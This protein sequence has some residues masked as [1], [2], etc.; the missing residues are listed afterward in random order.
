MRRQTIIA[1][2]TC[3][4]MA[5][6]SLMPAFAGKQQFRSRSGNGD[7]TAVLTQEEIDDLMFMREEEKLARD[8]YITQ[9]VN[10]GTL[11][12]YNISLSEESHTTAVLS[13]IEKYRLEDPA[14][15]AIGS[16]TDPELQALYDELTARAEA[17]EL[18]A[19]LVGA[20]IEEVDFEDIV[21]AM[22]R[23]E[24]SDIL[25]VY[26]NLLNGSSNHLNAYVSVIEDRTGI[27][28]T[29]QYLPQEVVDEILGR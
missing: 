18:E 14:K 28:Y 19:L 10:W 16:F 7:G 17:S 5:T 11:I 21:N 27:P 2:S 6:Y 22:E 26:G 9:Y 24:R 25:Q 13:L 1:I 8:T 15:E 12:F 23:T 3:V 20:L 4:I 29:A